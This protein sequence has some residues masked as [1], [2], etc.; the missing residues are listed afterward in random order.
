VT[1][2]LRQSPA[3]AEMVAQRVSDNG[4]ES[5]PFVLAHGTVRGLGYP[6]V[7]RIGEAVMVSWSG[8]DG[9]EVKTALISATG[10]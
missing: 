5:A 2:W 1:V 9:K 6:R 10:R 3:D 4:P 8:K 7:Q